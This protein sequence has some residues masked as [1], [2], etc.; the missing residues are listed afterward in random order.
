MDNPAYYNSEVGLT[1]PP[2]PQKKPLKKTRDAPERATL[3]K[4]PCLRLWKLHFKTKEASRYRRT[5]ALFLALVILL[6]VLIVGIA[7]AIYI[8]VGGNLNWS[9]TRDSTEEEGSWAVEGEFRVTNR[10][11]RM[12]MNDHTSVTFLRMAA[13]VTKS[14]DELFVMS[15]LVRDYNGTEII[16]FSKG[17]VIVSC[18]I[19]LNRPFTKAAEQVGLTFVQ[20]LEQGHGMLPTGS[21]HVDITSIRFAGRWLV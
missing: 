5:V 7:L 19:F 1:I 18:R 8:S 10:D 14:M 11:Y 13:E 15:P 4:H 2:H 21:L 16:G 3:E 12:D 20:A 17:S 9:N 6:I